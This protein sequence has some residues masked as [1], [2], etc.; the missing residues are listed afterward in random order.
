MWL[1]PSEQD[2]LHR[3]TLASCSM[4]SSSSA[5]HLPLLCK[6][7]HELCHRSVLHQ[8]PLH[9]GTA[10]VCSMQL[11]ARRRER[12]SAQQGQT[13]HVGMQ[14]PKSH[15]LLGNC[16]SK[17]AAWRFRTCPW[18]YNNS[19]TPTDS[20]NCRLNKPA[21]RILQFLVDPSKVLHLL[22]KRGH[23]ALWREHKLC[24]G[25]FVSYAYCTPRTIVCTVAAHCLVW[26]SH[27]ESAEAVWLSLPRLV[28]MDLCTCCSLSANPTP[29]P[30][31]HWRALHNCLIRFTTA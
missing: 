4:L 10:G 26:I 11:H 21:H 31:P 14:T 28:H 12:S 5:P 8:V 30:G 19:V 22:L 18:V 17:I 24:S 6:Q 25:S 9:V 27:Q 13:Q 29:P 3:Q 15:A 7:S 23:A 16:I 20:M 1:A 2:A